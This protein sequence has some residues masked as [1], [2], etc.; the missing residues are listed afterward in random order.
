MIVNDQVQVTIWCLTY[1]HREYIC[2]ALDGFIN[3]ITNFKYKIAIYDDASTDGTSNIIKEY[4]ERYPELFDITISN[5]NRYSEGELDKFLIEWRRKKF[6]G[7]YTA[8]CEG[9]DC[10]IDRYKLQRQY[11]FMEA[12]PNYSLCMHNAI[13]VDYEKK[14]IRS[15]II[16]TDG[17]TG[18]DKEPEEIIVQKNVHPPTASFFLKS[19]IWNLPEFFF[20]GLVLDYP[21]QL[22]AL[23][24][25][26]IYCDS[27]YMSVYRCCT[28]GSHGQRV[29]ENKSFSACIW[30]NLINF[31]LRY[32]EYTN[33][34]FSDYVQEAITKYAFC[35]I[36]T[37]EKEEN[38]EEFLYKEWNSGNISEIP[39]KDIINK[40]QEFC[41]MLY[42]KEYI[43]TRILD[44]IE[45]NKK[46]SIMGAGKY[47]RLLGRK[48]IDNS[49]FFEGYVVSDLRNNPN[50]IDEKK[51]CLMDENNESSILVGILPIDKKNIMNSLKKNKINNYFFV[52][53]I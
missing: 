43:P 14:G 9:D 11:D 34:K 51:V 16:F 23:S 12:N 13:W 48:L 3:Q 47:S 35:F 8:I 32:N 22:G 29:K 7:K 50:E 33:Y 1:N 31:L 19:E 45:K 26:E 25:G 40:L 42:V 27:R 18:M 38:I 28:A 44:Y 10:W 20:R 6:E 15:D 36:E 41:S 37:I 52:Y 17:I 4:K 30:I 2:D 46:I 5:H 49:I 21:L 24:I 53:N 39:N